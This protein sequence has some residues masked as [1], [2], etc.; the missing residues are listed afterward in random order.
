M[1][2]EAWEALI[3]GEINSTF[4]V[5]SYIQVILILSAL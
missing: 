5:G 2:L 3:Y 1:Y 4:I